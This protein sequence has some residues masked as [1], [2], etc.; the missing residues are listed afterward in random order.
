MILCENLVSKRMKS[1]PHY[2]EVENAAN[3]GSLLLFCNWLRF[4]FR[5]FRGRLHNLSWCCLCRRH[6]SWCC[7]CRRHLSWC[8]LCRRRR[9]SAFFVVYAFGKF[10]DLIL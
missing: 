4:C 1:I 9:S 5:C 8:C 2:G 3:I 10:D 6:L 7:L